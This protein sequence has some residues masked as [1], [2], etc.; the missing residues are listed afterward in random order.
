MNTE[1]YEYHVNGL[2]NPNHPENQEMVLEMNADE[3]FNNSPEN[4]ISEITEQYIEF[5]NKKLR[6]K[7]KALKELH[8]EAE[9][10]EGATYWKNKLWKI[11]KL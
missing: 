9:A 8:D 7:N 11:Y 10:I 2:G 4:E 1:N 3:I 5:L 6:E